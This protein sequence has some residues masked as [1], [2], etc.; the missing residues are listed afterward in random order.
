MHNLPVIGRVYIF[1][2]LECIKCNRNIWKVSTD[3]FFFTFF[4]FY[5]SWISTK[6][7]FSYKRD[8]E[9][10]TNSFVLLATSPIFL[11]L[12][13]LNCF[14]WDALNSFSPASRNK[15][16]RF[17]PLFCFPS[18]PQSSV[19]YLIFDLWP[20]FLFFARSQVP[21]LQHFMPLLFLFSQMTKWLIHFFFIFSSD[22]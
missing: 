7:W 15:K 1:F 4:F 14:L 20:S 2:S 5:V 3:H 13:S 18:S 8:N 16:A 17:F 6:V 10:A 21:P 22:S 19:E 9:I 11:L 12:L